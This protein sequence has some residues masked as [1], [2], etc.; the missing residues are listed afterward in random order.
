MKDLLIEYRKTRLCVLNKIKSLEYKVDEGDKLSIY[1]DI[2]KDIDYT[3]EWLTCGH[4][5]GNYNAIDRSQCYL[6]DNDVINKAF[7]ESMY[8]KVS[9]IEYND[10]INDVNNKVSYALMKLTPKELECFIMVKCEGLSLKQTAEL[11]E[12]KKPTIQKYMDR[13]NKK[14]DFQLC[15]NLFLS[16]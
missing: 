12:V 15:N 13:I 11:L 2:L 16:N 1:K 3:I 14:I 8:K 5:P 10:I 6:V 4:E 7:S 9:D